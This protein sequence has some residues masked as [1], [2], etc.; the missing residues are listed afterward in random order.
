MPNRKSSDTGHISNKLLELCTSQQSVSQ[1]IA[2]DPSL[3]P[4]SAWKRLYGKHS[5]HGLSSSKADRKHH[6]TPNSEEQQEQE[7]NGTAASPGTTAAAE[8]T[9]NSDEVEDSELERAFKCGKWG[10][11]ERP[12][13]LFLKVRVD[14]YVR[15]LLSPC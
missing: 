15:L 12:S 11:N 10:R 5:K 9:P 6:K 14:I 1:L 8:I 4:G 3:S 2:Q 13:D 7:S